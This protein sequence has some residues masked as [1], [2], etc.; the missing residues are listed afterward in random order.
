MSYLDRLKLK[1]SQ[2]ALGMGATKVSKAPY[3][4]FVATPAV[5]LR[6]ISAAN[7]CAPIDREAFEERAAI[8]E[9]DGGLSRNEALGTPRAD[10]AAEGR[11]Q[12]VVAMLAHNPG[13][14][15]AMI[16]DIDADPD[17]VILALAIRGKATCEFRIPKA[18]YEPSLLL[19]L[20]QRQ[21]GTVH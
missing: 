1:I 19:D 3:V 8:M 13:I 6:Q 15:Y 18:K 20:I 10:P 5:P 16:T 17:A 9:F 4:P 2:D 11:R 14:Q 12:R 21:D 7:E